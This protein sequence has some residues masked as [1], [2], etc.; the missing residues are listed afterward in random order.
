MQILHRYVVMLHPVRVGKHLE[1]R[2]VAAND[3]MNAALALDVCQISIPGKLLRDSTGTAY[4]ASV[5]SLQYSSDYTSEIESAVCPE[6][7]I[8]DSYKCIFEIFR[9]LIICGQ[10]SVLREIDLVNQIFLII[11]YM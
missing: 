1:L 2:V 9:Q 3:G 7:L 10:F 8:F 4:P 6:R 5:E 11:I